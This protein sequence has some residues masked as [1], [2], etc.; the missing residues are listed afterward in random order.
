MFIYII[1]VFF[2]LL[3]CH[4][5]KKVVVIF[6]STIKGYNFC[7]IKTLRAIRVSN[8]FNTDQAKRSVCSDLGPTFC[9]D[10]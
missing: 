2:N 9:K 8:S 10:W 7:H 4:I 5:T 6:A 3:L 1:F